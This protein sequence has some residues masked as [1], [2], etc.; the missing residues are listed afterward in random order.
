[1][2]VRIETHPGEGVTHHMV[3]D[4]HGVLVDLSGVQHSVVNA[5][6]FNDPAVSRV[7]WGLHSLPDGRGGLRTV[8]GGTVHLRNGSVQPFFDRNLLDPYLAAYRARKQELGV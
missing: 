3:V 8:E 7:E 6:S 2:R 1:M 5:Q 4:N